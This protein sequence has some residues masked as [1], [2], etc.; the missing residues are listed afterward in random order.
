MSAVVDLGERLQLVDPSQGHFRTAVGRVGGLLDLVD[1]GAR[2]LRGGRRLFGAGGDGVHRL[3]EFHH[4]AVGFGDGAGHLV[5]RGGQLLG[6]GLRAGQRPG[7][8][9]FLGHFLG[10]DAVLGDIVAVPNRLGGFFT[11]GGD[12][13]PFCG[14]RRF[15][16][17]R[18]GTAGTPLVCASAFCLITLSL[19]VSWIE[20]AGY[21]A[22][23]SDR[24]PP[25][26]LYSPMVVF[27]ARHQ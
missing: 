16:A 22:Q 15:M 10:G 6:H 27:L 7:P 21:R 23:R 5:G 2:L 14:P 11:G 20:R 26:F 24:R 4:R 1:G 19:E 3:L 25:N 12:V 13:E 18:L 17:R 9:L 8:G